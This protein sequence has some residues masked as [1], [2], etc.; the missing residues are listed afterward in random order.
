MPKKFPIPT[1]T[2][3]KI[4][5]ALIPLAILPLVRR[6]IITE[7]HLKTRKI[8]LDVFGDNFRLGVKH[9]EWCANIEHNFLKQSIESWRRGDRLVALVLYATAVEQHVNSMYQHIIPAQGW[10]SS[11]VTNLLREVNMDAKLDWMFEAFAKRR[12]PAALKKR[13]RTVFAIRNAIVHFKGEVAPIE[14]YADS[15]TKLEEQL[16]SLRRLSFS[17]DFRLLN[18]TFANAVL[19]CDPDRE[20]VQQASEML[21]R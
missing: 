10:T 3:N 7:E 15:H 21:L 11:Q 9:M 16:K 1:R 19:T 17:R 6:R 5:R 20:I 14:S 13:L 12:F 2:A 18:E 4:A 8:L